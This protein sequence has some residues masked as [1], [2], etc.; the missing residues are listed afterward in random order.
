M[1]EISTKKRIERKERLAVNVF[2]L[3]RIPAMV[4]GLLLDGKVDTTKPLF[5]DKERPDELGVEFIC[6]LLNAA[7]TCDVLRNEGRR[8]GVPMRAYIRQR[9]SWTR[10]PHS[11]VLTEIVGD[12]CVLNTELFPPTDAEMPTPAPYETKPLEW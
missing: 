7:A 8:S 12:T 4:R 1:P 2:D 10:L 6:D 3:T 11:A 9:G 5:M